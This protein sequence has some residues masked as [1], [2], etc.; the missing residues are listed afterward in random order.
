MPGAQSFLITHF[1]A[2]EFKALLLHICFQPLSLV[3]TLQIWQSESSTFCTAGCRYYIHFASQGAG[4]ALRGRGR[5]GPRVNR[6]SFSI[7]HSVWLEGVKALGRLTARKLCQRQK[8][9]SKILFFAWQNPRQIFRS[10]IKSRRIKE[11][12]TRAAPG[13]WIRRFFAP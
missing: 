7:T 13:V 8:L 10:K 2:N 9:I 4:Q 12:K 3:M 5:V 6:E 11:V 1:I